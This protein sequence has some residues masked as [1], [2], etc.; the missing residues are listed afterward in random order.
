MDIVKSYILFF[1]DFDN[2]SGISFILRNHV[3]SVPS[4]TLKKVPGRVFNRTGTYLAYMV[5][6]QLLFIRGRFFCFQGDQQPAVFSVRDELQV[7]DLAG[8]RNKVQ[9]QQLVFF[10]RVAHHDLQDCVLR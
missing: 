10:R 8:F 4:A 7:I 6:Q 9:R 5:L 2:G 3:S 1:Y